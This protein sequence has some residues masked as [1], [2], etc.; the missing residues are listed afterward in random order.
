M[1]LIPH[2]NTTNHPRQSRYP[3]NRS[4]WLFTAF[5]AIGLALQAPAVFG[6]AGPVGGLR[7][8]QDSFRQISRG[9]K[10]AVVNISAVRTIT[11]RGSSVEED[12]FFMNDPFFRHFFQDE[13]L[14]RFFQL[15]TQPREY[16]QQGLGSGFIFDPR[17]YILT[18]RHVIRGADQIIVT[19]AGDKKYNARLIGADPKTDVAV[20][21]IDGQNLPHAK[22]G[23]SAALEVGDWVLAIGNPFGLEKTVTAGIVSAKG[24]SKM[25][26]LEDED[27]IQTDAAI[28]RGNSGGPLVNIDGHVIGMNTAIVTD[29]DSRGFLGIGFA[30]PI[31]AVKK[32]A[33]AIMAGKHAPQN[34]VQRGIGERQPQPVA[35]RAPQDPMK[36]IYPPGRSPGG[37]VL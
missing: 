11:T 4:V 32:S 25:G 24:R 22:L 28:N 3:A 20:L 17:G 35:P 23:N 2:R 27:F 30:I 26:I 19:L 31:N 5:F 33:E 6:Q 16:R 7:S 36:Q 37:S 1:A 18:N 21:K 29:N 13:L 34:A 10:P 15:R 14:R 12:P 8:L 9:V